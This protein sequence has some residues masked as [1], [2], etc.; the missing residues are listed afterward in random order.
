MKTITKIS[1]IVCAAFLALAATGC[2]KGGKPDTEPGLTGHLMAREG[3][4][5]LVIDT[6]AQD[7]SSTGGVDSF[8]NAIWFSNAPED[9]PLGETVSVWF[10]AVAES[11]PGQS[12]A[13]HV[14]VVPSEKPP[15]ADLT[16]AQALNLA[17]TGPEYIQTSAV[18]SIAYE[19]ETDLW[20]FGMQV[21]FEE[22]AY[23]ITVA[24]E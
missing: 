9:I 20:T 5:I 16:Q 13:I 3:G 23:T 17:L 10:D 19:A 2:A 15:G 21:L 6:Q 11:Y 18:T 7:F 24:D 1:I 22:T 8:Y 4:R 12:E 14:E